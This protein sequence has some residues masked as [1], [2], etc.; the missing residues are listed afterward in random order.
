MP[1]ILAGFDYHS[2]HCEQER[3]AF[4]AIFPRF[5]NILR[6]KNAAHPQ[7][8]LCLL[9]NGQPFCG[10]IYLNQLRTVFLFSVSVH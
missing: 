8:K 6:K 2:N 5:L 9:S 10:I 7:K 3:A 4:K 1:V